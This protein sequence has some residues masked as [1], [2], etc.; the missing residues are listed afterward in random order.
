MCLVDTQAVRL[1]RRFVFE[2]ISGLGRR[3]PKA[4]IIDG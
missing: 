1:G 4:C 3:V 2:Y